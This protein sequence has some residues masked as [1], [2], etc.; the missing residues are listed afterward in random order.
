VVFLDDVTFRTVVSSSPLVSI[1]LVI[2]DGEGRVLLGQRKNRPA[3]HSWFVL[4]GR[5]QKNEVIADAFSRVV[6]A[7]LGLA[8]PIDQA[9]FLGIYDHLYSD[10]IWGEEV[11]THYVA[12][13]FE[14][15]VSHLRD[16][17]LP[18]LLPD[19][20]HADYRWFG[21]DELL[22]SDSV[23]AHTKRYFIEGFGYK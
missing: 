16:K 13:A 6:E 12:S 21:V 18:R 4:G 20:Q 8:I 5:I 19:K 2:Y 15:T 1:D 9:R 3:Q 14:I 7:E 22:N 23:H 10:S 17:K 11:T